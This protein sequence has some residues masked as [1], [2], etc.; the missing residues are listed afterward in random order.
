MC[1]FGISTNN[2]ELDLPSLQCI[3]N[4][5]KCPYTHVSLSNVSLH[6]RESVKCFTKPLSQ[7]HALTSILSAVKTGLQNY[8]DN[9]YSRKKKQF[10]CIKSFCKIQEY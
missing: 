8:C 7:L 1:S 4:L 6:T 3:P 5:H 10:H 9:R 2:E